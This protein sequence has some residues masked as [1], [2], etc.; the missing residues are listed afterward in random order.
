[1]AAKRKLAV[2]TP[3]DDRADED[4]QDLP[5]T[6]ASDLPSSKPNW[7]WRDRLEWATIAFLQGG[8]C[9]GKSSW[10]R[11]IAS[12]VTGG[13]LLPGMKGK[14]KALGHV[15]WFAGEEALRTRVRPG[16]EA[17]GADL[18][19]C[20]LF[21]LEDEDDSRHLALPR[22]V[23]RLTR[24]VQQTGSK[25][26]VLD[27][28]F[29]F[30]DGTHDLEGPTVPARRFMAKLQRVAT[31]TGC[32]ILTSRNLTKDTSRGALA[33]G[34]GGAELGNAARAVL[35]C[36]ALPD[37]PRRFG[38]AVA[39]N[40]NGAPVAT[41]TYHFELKGDVASVVVDGSTES[42][43][44]DL[45]AGDE[46]DLEKYAKDRAKELIKTMLPRGRMKSTEIKQV[47]EE[48]MIRP[49]TLLAAAKALGVRYERTGSRENTE[50]FW[51]P[52]LGGYK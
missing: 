4:Y 27:P 46:G 52:P 44:D 30:S 13:P 10:L 31:A 7:F 40:N 6:L 5:D 11:T 50:C 12:Y 39:A 2:V 35:H 29:N 48:A 17:A 25:L 36:Q 19:K 47:A 51:L 28:I 18:S 49:G 16:L 14:R 34:R 43:A 42:T 8:K 15:C 3:P 21:D 41:I 23:E 20:H 33:A 32:L 37:N 9:A 26:V 24:K 45:S 1:M 38:L 22:D